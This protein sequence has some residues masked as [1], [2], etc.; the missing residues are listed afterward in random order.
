MATCTYC[1]R[2]EAQVGYKRCRVCKLKQR[3]NVARWREE[4]RTVKP[5]SQTY[6]AIY[7]RARQRGIR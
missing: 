1:R 3:L 7:H 2:Y 6:G 4:R 5:L